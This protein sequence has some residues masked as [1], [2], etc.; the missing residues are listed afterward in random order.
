MK[1][2]VFLL[3]LLFIGSIA[4]PVFGESISKLQESSNTEMAIS[5]IGKHAHK[6]K[7]TKTRKKKTVHH[8]KA[9][10]HAPK[11]SK[12]KTHKKK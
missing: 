5:G 9:K 12:T 2:T 4:F 7:T 3:L 6:A 1:K 10:K 11:P 8:K